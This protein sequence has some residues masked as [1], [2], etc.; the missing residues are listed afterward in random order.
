LPSPLA[1]KTGVAKA[2]QAAAAHGRAAHS[3]AA[4]L[5]HRAKEQAVD[6]AK[7]AAV[8]TVK[9]AVADKILGREKNKVQVPLVI[10]ALELRSAGTDNTTTSFLAVVFSLAR[11]RLWCRS[12]RLL[13]RRDTPGLGGRTMRATERPDLRNFL[14]IG[15]AAT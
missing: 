13:D 8:D 1:L 3:A 14:C 12:S 2:G 4:Q 5:A 10:E 7:D 6:A 11:L 9:H 15:S